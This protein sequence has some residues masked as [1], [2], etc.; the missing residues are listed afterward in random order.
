MIKA[1]NDALLPLAAIGVTVVL[2]ASAFVAIRHVGREFSPGGMALFRLLVAGVVLG[3]VVA[4]RRV[5]RPEGGQAWPGRR[6]LPRLIAC[7]V[8]WFGL[9]NVA[10]NEAERRVDAGTAAMLVN[11][12]PI[13]IAVLAGFFLHEGFPRMLIIGSLIAFGGV[14]VIGLATSTGAETNVWGVVLCVVAAIAYAIGVVTQKPLLKDLPGLHVTWLACLI[15]AVSCLPFAPDLIDDL[16]TA[17]PATI[18]WVVYLGVMPTALAF[19]TWAYAL[20]RSSAGRLGAATYL[21]P[22][23]A[24]LMGWLL[25]GETPAA[26]ALVGGVIC[27]AGVYIARRK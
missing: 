14:V 26:L 2:W 8:L 21:V 13:L 23:L 6:H 20:A 5:E 7:G 27:L 11:I 15:G 16:S 10:L 18:W 3:A 4:F 12:G 24:I 1:R 25:L 17:A 22:P 9:Y 19:T